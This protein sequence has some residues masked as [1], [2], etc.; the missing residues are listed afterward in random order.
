MS[1]MRKYQDLH[2]IITAIWD[3]T[4][5]P[6]EIPEVSDNETDPNNNN[7]LNN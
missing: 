6:E 4:D 5:A 7:D 2:V 1:K 3:L